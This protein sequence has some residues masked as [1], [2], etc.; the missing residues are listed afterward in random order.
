VWGCNSFQTTCNAEEYREVVLRRANIVKEAMGKARGAST[1]QIVDVIADAVLN[2]GGLF[3]TLIDLYPTMIADAA[4]LMLPAAHPGE[5][6]LTSMNGERRLRLSEKF[7]DPPGA[8]R[9]DCLIAADIANTL[10]ALYQREGNAAMAK[11]F[12]GFEWKTEEDAFNDGFRRAGRPGAPPIDSQGGDTGYL[13]T[14]EL[15]RMAGN[16][17]VQLPIKEVK[18]GKLVGTEMI[19][20]D[21]KFST[22]DGKAK[23]LPAPWPGLPKPVV[24]QKQKHKFYVNNGRVNEVW[25]T[26][27]HNKYDPHVKERY[28]MAIVELN[29]SDARDLGVASGDIVEL[30]NDYGSTYALAYPDGAIKQGHTFMQFG[31]Y[32]GV[33]GDVVTEWTD[34]NII[35]YYKGTWASI[36]RIGG[37]DQFRRTVS[38]KSRRYQT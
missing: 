37:G 32:N 36:R 35:P 5:M 2:K 22:P 9:P 7:M 31:W 1:E 3:V 26:G 4:H 28:P 20:T 38:F 17:G 33:V 21:N 30:Y 24:A 10:K 8:A 25:Q 19:Y 13:A 12:E 16:N 18:S 15:L 11:R 27:Y 6:N 29:P 34:R 23:F 14:Y